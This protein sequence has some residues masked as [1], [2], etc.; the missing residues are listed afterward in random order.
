[1]WDWCVVFFS[2]I[3]KFLVHAKCIGIVLLL[4]TLDKVTLKNSTSKHIDPKNGVK[5]YV[6]YGI[7]AQNCYTQ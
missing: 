5:L 3:K 1:M 7:L 2:C 6:G 4:S